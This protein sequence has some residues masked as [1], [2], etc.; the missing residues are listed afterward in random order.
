MAACFPLLL[1]QLGKSRTNFQQPPIV[2]EF[3]N[4]A[5][6]MKAICIISLVAI[7]T[8]RYRFPNI[9]SIM[10]R[11]STLGI[12]TF[13]SPQQNEWSSTESG[14]LCTLMNLI[15]SASLCQYWRRYHFYLDQM[16]ASVWTAIKPVCGIADHLFFFS[17]WTPCCSLSVEKVQL[18][19]NFYLDCEKVRVP[20][21]SQIL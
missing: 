17:V 15:G 9:W 18:C 11:A 19:L 6:S 7:S 20:G 16:I 13:S 14:I 2:S 12:P 4:A 21:E 1:L 8:Q 10:C 3:V 5:L